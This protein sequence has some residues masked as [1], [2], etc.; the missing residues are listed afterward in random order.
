M[1]GFIFC[2]LNKK[3]FLFLQASKFYVTIGK[4]LYK[5]I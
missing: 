2:G 5:F 4:Q 1:E 3:V